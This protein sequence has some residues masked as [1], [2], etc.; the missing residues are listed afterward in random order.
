[1]YAEK[2]RVLTGGEGKTNLRERESVEMYHESKNSPNMSLFIVTIL[3]AYYLLYLFVCLFYKK[4]LYFI[5]YQMN[6]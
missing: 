2:E 4:K 6:K 3:S 1:V 5:S